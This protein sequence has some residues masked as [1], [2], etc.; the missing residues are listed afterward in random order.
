MTSPQSPTQSPGQPDA[1][2]QEPT[3]ANAWHQRVVAF[4]VKFVTFVLAGGVGF[5]IDIAATLGLVYVG[6][7]KFSARAIGIV[8]AMGVTYVLNR[9]ITFRDAKS[10]SGKAEAAEGMRYAAVGIATSVLNWVVY[11]AV[12]SLFPTLWPVIGIFCGSIAAMIVSYV[13][14]DKLVFRG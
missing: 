8:I 12:L 3:T 7:D 14:Y 10:A 4:A 1:Q 5:A 2:S 13:G 6:V 11:A 9:T